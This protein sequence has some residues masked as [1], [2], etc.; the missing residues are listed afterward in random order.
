MCIFD[1]VLNIT[2]EILNMEFD[3]IVGRPAI[4]A[5]PILARQ[6]AIE[7]GVIPE[8]HSDGRII[9]KLQE[10]VIIEKGKLLTNQVE[11][12]PDFPDD[13]EI[14]EHEVELQ[15]LIRAEEGDAKPT[16]GEDLSPEGKIQLED[17]CNRFSEVFSQNLR[18]IPAKV[19][20][21]KFSVNE[22]M[23][24]NRKNRGPPRG[25]TPQRQQEMESLVRECLALDLIEESDAE[26]YSHGLLKMKPDGKY[27]FCVDFK[28]LNACIESSI[29]WPITNLPQM[30]NRLGD[31]KAELFG[32]MDLTKGYFQMELDESS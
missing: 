31:S 12:Q 20:K 25:S 14:E 17:L 28:N 32:V 10:E 2:F 29:G 9:H 13:P 26:Y 30:I 6:W 19:R 23:W 8:V 21:M 15:D 22:Q 18:P 5:Y 7:I 16:F 4:E 3:V 11:E 24:H 1:K 27:R